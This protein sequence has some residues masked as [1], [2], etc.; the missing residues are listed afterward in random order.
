MRPLK[1]KGNRAY[2]VRSKMNPAAIERLNKHIDIGWY[3]H[4]STSD[5]VEV[6]VLS[7]SCPFRKR[8]VTKEELG[9]GQLCNELAKLAAKREFDQFV[10]GVDE[11]AYTLK[12]LGLKSSDFVEAMRRVEAKASAIAG[13]QLLPY[14]IRK[15]LEMARQKRTGTLLIV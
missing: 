4:E 11:L 2:A 14:E 8:D 5:D 10:Q 15:H 3:I 12:S 6:Y 7:E 1:F 9:I 13:N